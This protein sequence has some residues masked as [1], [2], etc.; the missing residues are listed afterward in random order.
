[1]KKKIAT[2]ILAG[3]LTCSVCSCGNNESEISDNAVNTETEDRKG[4]Q[5]PEESRTE[6]VWNETEEDPGENTQEE[7]HESGTEIS[8]GEEEGAF[9]FSDLVGLE[10]CFAS[11]A[12]AW[13]TEMTVHGDGSFSGVYHDTDM[14]D[15]G[16]GYPN[17]TVYRCDFSGQF[18]QPVKINEYT[19]SM[20]IAEIDYVKEA[21]TEEIID[22]VR[23]CYSDVYGLDGAKDILVYLPGAPL[24]ELPEEFRSWVGYYD[25]AKM[26]ETELPFYALNNE[27]QQY[28]FSSYD[29]VE[30]LEERIS[31]IEGEAASLEASIQNDVLTQMEY[32][33]KTKELYDL[34]DAALNDVWN[35]L[36]Q[37][38]DEETMSALTVEE[39]EW[40]A[41]KEQAVADAGAEY[42][43]GS[44]QP[45]IVNQKA[46]ELTK[47]R[48]YELLEHLGIEG[49][50]S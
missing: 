16:D 9:S 3:I 31:S 47:E 37:T 8:Q 39:R 25:L 10:F 36:K 12:G 32:N 43:G 5:T 40:I 18:T 48:V 29:L 38:Q 26:T 33:E 35:V 22:G 46:A 24:A 30:S 44:I 42:E 21:G 4:G 14:G 2:L 50:E 11:G 6:T 49:T 15:G 19:Y 34:W 1:M 7:T 13:S 45:M 41:A 17:G 27:A 20:Q 28:G 23:Y